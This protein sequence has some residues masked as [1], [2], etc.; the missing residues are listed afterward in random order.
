MKAL[1]SLKRI[2]PLTRFLLFG[3]ILELLF[4]LICMLLPFNTP[5]LIKLPSSTVWSWIFTPAQP[6]VFKTSVP[7]LKFTGIGS[8]FLLLCLVIIAL[9]SVYLFIAGNASH[10]R[11]NIPITSRWL[12]LPVIGASI[13]GIT[14][15]LLPALFNN[16]T[17]SFI[18]KSLA[19]LSHLINCVL[20]WTIL[21]KLAPTR[22]LEGTL[23]YA[24]NPLALIELAGYGNNDGLL[25]FFLLLATLLIIQLKSRW[26]DFWGMVFLGCA[27]SMNAIALLFTLMMICFCALRN[28]KQ[29]YSRILQPDGEHSATTIPL[30]SGIREGNYVTITMEICLESHCRTRNSICSLSP[31]LASWLNI[32]AHHLVLRH[33]ILFTL[34]IKH[35]GNTFSLAQQHSLSNLA[36]NYRLFL[37]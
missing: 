1:T 26:Y 28:R 37:R 31:I 3:S 4:L 13:F 10:I 7:S 16:E 8:H 17:H 9:S 19:F 18:F 12:L 22:R 25:L 6:F 21:S 20:I 36:F 32:P 27:M 2:S 15:V 29:S 23:L 14:L 34:T 5:N 30:T 24:W 33:A 35:A 11:N